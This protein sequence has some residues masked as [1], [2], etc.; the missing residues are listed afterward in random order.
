MTLN[1]RHL[2]LAPVALWLGAARSVRADEGPV[3]VA[4]VS[5]DRLARVAGVDLLLNGTGVRAV[6]WFKGYAAGLYL[7]ARA[8]TAA[9]VTAVPGPK[10]LQL[11]LLRD[12]SSAEF[13]KALRVGMPRNSPPALVPQLAERMDKLAALIAALEEVHDG[14]LINLDYEPARGLV[15]VVNGKARGEAIPGDDFYGALLRV[16]VGDHPSDEKLKAGLLGHAA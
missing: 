3:K 7:T 10:R 1:R 5:C 2:L 9:E 13:V 15:F 8:G 6:A 12:V 16:F 11:R 14:D 4:G